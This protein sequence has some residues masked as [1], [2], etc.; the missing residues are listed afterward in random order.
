MSD[1][2]VQFEVLSA[3][4]PGA[5]AMVQLAGEAAREVL[6]ALTGRPAWRVGEAVFCALGDLDEG[7]VVLLGEGGKGIFPVAQIM[8]HGGLQVMG[9][10]KARLAELGC[11]EAVLAPQARYPEAA[12]LAEAQLLDTVAYAASPLALAFVC[13]GKPVPPVLVHP[14]MVAVVGHPNAGKSTLLNH[15]SGHTRAIVSAEPG[16]TRDFL[17][18]VVELTPDGNP[19]HAVAVRWFDTPGLRRTEDVVEREAI[20]LARQ[21]VRAAAVLIAM[22]EPAGAW[23]HDLPRLPDLWV[24]NKCDGSSGAQGEGKTQE[25]PVCISALTGW[26]VADLE[27]A[28]LGALGLWPLPCQEPCF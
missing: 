27:R 9:M 22:R 19:Q 5:V 26:G 6:T 25:T 14:P 16:T 11:H 4:A 28:V 1:F 15:L 7:M 18:G 13:A 20:A 10:L 17:A 12:D 8:P 2:R 3:P 24:V 23:P 21:A